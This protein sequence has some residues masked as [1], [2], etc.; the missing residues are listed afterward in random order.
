MVRQTPI[1]L[2]NQ[3]VTVISGGLSFD[4]Y[5]IETFS[6]QIVAS[7]VGRIETEDV[8][9]V[10]D[11]GVVYA[12][13]IRLFTPPTVS[14]AIGQHMEVGGQ[15]FKVNALRPM[16]DGRGIERF[17]VYVLDEVAD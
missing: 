3:E 17:K 14:G 16:V 15:K 12:T 4:E 8:R 13:S 1:H 7:G 2:F 6:E 9:I 11:G 5:G 10:E